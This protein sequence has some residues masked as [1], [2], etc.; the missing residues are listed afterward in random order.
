ME[1]QSRTS[2]ATSQLPLRSETKGAD[3]NW[4]VKVLKQ[5]ADF[6]G[7]ARRMEY[8]MFVLVNTII[9]FLLYLPAIVTGDPLWAILYYLYA[10]AVLI[11]GLAVAVR[12]LHDTDRSGWWILIGL[13]PLVGMIILLVFMVQDSEQGPNRYGPSPKLGGEGYYARPA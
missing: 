3:V 4:Y 9:A 13:V 1:N 11:P 7:R 2:R 6:S 12:R 5:Y 8:W 10:L